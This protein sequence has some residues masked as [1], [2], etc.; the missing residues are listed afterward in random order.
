MENTQNCKYICAEAQRHLT[1]LSQGEVKYPIRGSAAQLLGEV[2]R[3]DYPAEIERRAQSDG[4]DTMVLSDEPEDVQPE[5]E[6]FAPANVWKCP[7]TWRRDA[8]QSEEN[9]HYW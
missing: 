8:D 2:P 7:K 1:L 3:G 4:S 6:T 9:M 5:D